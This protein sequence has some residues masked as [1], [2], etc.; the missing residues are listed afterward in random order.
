MW[1]VTFK[2]ATGDRHVPY[3]DVVEE[4]LCCGWVDSQGRLLDDA[5]SQL[6][7]T[8]RKRG[9]NWSRKNKQRI[10]RLL[11]AGLIAPAG[12]AAVESAK[13]DGSW[14]ALDAVEDLIE[15]DDLR[16]A[17][18]AD[19]EARRQWGRFPPSTRRGILEWIGNAKR[20]PTR[21]KRIAETAGLAA[22]GIRANQWR[23]PGSR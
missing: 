19:P 15:P 6:L 10:D 9:S 20:A 3:D 22:A 4:A 17:L 11:A 12:L 8:P 18:D 1:L 14:T 2:K 16:A 23:R 5:R 13:A 7:M 21:G